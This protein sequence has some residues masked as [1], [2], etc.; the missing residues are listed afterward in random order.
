MVGLGDVRDDHR[1]SHRRGRTNLPYHCLSLIAAGYL[2]SQTS[3][4]REPL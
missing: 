3:S 4:Q 1:R 2:S